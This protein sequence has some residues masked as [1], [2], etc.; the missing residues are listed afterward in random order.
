MTQQFS[1]RDVLL[2]AAAGLAAGGYGASVL[3]AQEDSP[4]GLPKR[5][6][7]NTGEKVSL[8][9]LGGWHI[10]SIPES[11]SIRLMHEA[12]DQGITFFDNAWDYHDGAA[13]TVMGKALAD[14]GRRDKIFLMTKVCDR[15]YA[16]VKKQ[17]D[18]SLRRLQTDRIDL[19]Q[20]HEINYPSDPDWV[21]D[22]GGLKAALEARKA[23]KIRFIG[24]TGHKDISFLLAMLKK[25]FDWATAQMPINVHDAHYRSFQKEVLPECVKRK[26]GAIGMK[27]LACGILPKE[28]GLD[29]PLCRRYALSLPISTLVCGIASRE[30]LQQDLAVGRNFKPMTA[31]EIQQLLA[32][33]REAGSQGKFEPFKTEKRFDGGYHRRQHDA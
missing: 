29:A 31:A 25:P 10:A 32:E 5:P 2:A 6:L 1:R 4:T 20:F 30:N 12:I 26:I 16:G 13:E 19:L 17:I 9:G 21:F 33:T 27:S 22:K 23:G 14:G 28:A 8:I 24:F 7:G 15:D 18:Q 3:A 11:E